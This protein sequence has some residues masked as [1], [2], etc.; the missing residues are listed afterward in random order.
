M[1]TLTFPDTSTGKQ[2]D[3]YNSWASAATQ[4]TTNN[5]PQ[6]KPRT[7]TKMCTLNFWFAKEDF[8]VTLTIKPNTQTSI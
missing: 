6:N 8:I 1:K 5:L 2:E 4:V 3:S 7:S